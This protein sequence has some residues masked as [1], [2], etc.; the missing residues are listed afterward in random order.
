[1]PLPFFSNNSARPF[2]LI[3]FC[4]FVLAGLSGFVYTGLTGIQPCPLCMIERSFYFIALPLS[5]LSY[6]LYPNRTYP[7]LYRFCLLL[8]IISMLLNVGFS[9]YHAGIENKL[10][11]STFCA[12]FA[13][14]A[15]NQAKTPSELFAQLQKTTQT[16]SCSQ[17]IASLFSVSLIWWNLFMALF[18]AFFSF[19]I[20]YLCPKK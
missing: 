20:G 6:L 19:F 16:P 11:D 12:H 5:L 4:F 10:W 9:L 14:Q 7:S 3:L 1:M 18:L 2:I 8:I 15:P 17:N 13:G